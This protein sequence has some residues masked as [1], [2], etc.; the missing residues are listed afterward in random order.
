LQGAC[1][2]KSGSTACSQRVELR[3]LHP[4]LR[5]LRFG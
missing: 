1:R 5:I 4:T 3:F 2:R